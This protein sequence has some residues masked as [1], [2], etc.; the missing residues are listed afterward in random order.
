MQEKGEGLISQAWS[1]RQGDPV[2]PIPGDESVLLCPLLCG[3]LHYRPGTKPPT[4]E[5][6]CLAS[7]GGL[8]LMKMSQSLTQTLATDFFT[9]QDQCIVTNMESRFPAM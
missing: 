2:S 9:R 6:W 7:N 5:L 1:C 4:Q 3:I 8:R